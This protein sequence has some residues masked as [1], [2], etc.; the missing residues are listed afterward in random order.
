MYEP[1]AVGRP[2]H[3][4]PQGEFLVWGQIPGSAVRSTVAWKDFA[5]IADQLLPK[6]SP[7]EDDRPHQTV[8]AMRKTN[9]PP[10][11][12]GMDYGVPITERDY[13]MALAMADL[14]CDKAARFFLL[15]MGLA[16]QARN[17]ESLK[18]LA[19]GLSHAFA[20]KIAESFS[21]QQLFFLWSDMIRKPL[22][23]IY[24]A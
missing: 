2:W 14:F 10:R 1:Q 13:T 15:A 6:L 8:S 9:F 24:Q 5:R 19:P 16:F 11:Q 18:I 17:L 22:I 12:A 3:D 21:F 23:S 20:G 4:C 7:S